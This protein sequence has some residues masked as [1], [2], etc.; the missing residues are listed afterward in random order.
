M[1]WHVAPR[2]KVS[3]F[4]GKTKIFSTE[5][6]FKKIT[7]LNLSKKNYSKKKC[8]LGTLTHTA[9]R[10]GFFFVTSGREKNPPWFFANFF[11]SRNL[12]DFVAFF[13]CFIVF[14]DFFNFF[15]F[16]YF[17]NFHNWILKSHNSKFQDGLPNLKI[18]TFYKKESQIFSKGKT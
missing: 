12:W 6:I 4:K 10:L 18:L 3:F 7:P 9:S 17:Q 2:K 14:V 11:Y 1:A 15:A 13:H 8:N 5:K 16:F